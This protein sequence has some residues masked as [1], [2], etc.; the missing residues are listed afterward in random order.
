MGVHESMGADFE[1]IF[2]IQN[3]VLKRFYG[4]NAGNDSNIVGVTLGLP[5]SRGTVKLAN[6]DPL[7]KPVIDPN[8]YSD[9]GNQDMEDV[10]DGE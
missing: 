9:P 3:N 4:P 5:R 7:S 6:S 1:K 2:G 8:Y 10:I